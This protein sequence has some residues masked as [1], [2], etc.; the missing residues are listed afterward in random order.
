MPSHSR[1][2]R[3]AFA[4]LALPAVLCAQRATPRPPTVAGPVDTAFFG[5]QWRNIGPNSTS[6]MVAVAGSVAR[7]KEYWFGTTGGGVWKTT[8]GGT[9]VVPVT[10][11][12][13]GGTIGAIAVS[14]SNPDV[15]YVG[16]GETPIRGNV[17]HGDGVWKTT[18]AGKTWTYVGLKETQYISR[19]R[20]H[21]TNPDI[22]YVGALGHVFGPN[23]E[24]GVFK[25]TDGGRT[26][27]K[28]LF[29]ND[30]T[31]IADL[32]V[33]PGNPNVLYAAFWQAWRRPW[34]L[35]SGGPGSGIFK[36]T[37]GGEHWTE[38]TRNPGLPAT[39]VLGRIGVA[40]SPAKPSRVWAIIEHE[41]AGGV[42]RSDDGG[43]NWTFLN[44]DR[45]LRQRAWYYTNI[46]ADPKDTNVVVAPQVG[47]LWSRD[48][49]KS[50]G[51]GFGGGDNHD[52]WWA[53][54]DP[55]RLAV[56]HDNGA[57]LT[58]DGGTTAVRV[59]IPTGQYYH[60]HLTNHYPYHVCGA[61]QDAGTSCGPVRVAGGGGRG[62]GGGG[63]GRGGGAA[64]SPFSEFYG[65]AGGESGYVASNPLDPDI[66]YGGNYSGVLQRQDRRT[67]LS[68]RL[69]PWPL[70]PMG[71]DAQDAKY[72]FQWTYPIMNSPHDPHVLYV[73]ANVLFKSSDDGRTWQVISPD[74]TRHD[75]RTLGS[76]GGPI[77]KDQTSVEYYATIFAAAES[78]VTPG[79]IWA[80][81]DD[82]L[83]HVTRD[84]GKTWRNVTP[85]GFPEW[86]RVSII[87]PSPHHA[88]TAYVAANRFQMD[89][90]A[91]YLY[92]TTD[93][94]ATWTK[95]TDGITGTEFTRAIR[96]DLVRPGL[97]YAA[98]ERGVWLSYDAGG[99]WQ[100]LQRN[101]PPV[102]VH[103]IALKHDD[104]VIATHGRAFWVMENLTPLREAPEVALAAGKNYFYRPAPVI[105]AGGAPATVMYRLAQANQPVTI[106]FL[107]AA[108]KLIRKF[109]S[110]DSQPGAAGGRGGG[111]GA[112]AGGG[113]GG[114]GGAPTVTTRAGVNSYQWNLRYPD[115]SSFQGMIF[116]AGGVQ[117]P[118]AAPG[119]YTVRLTVGAE[120]PI[121]Q[122]LVIK[123]DPRAKATDADLVAQHQLAIKVRDRVTEANDAVKTMR[124]VYRQLD[125]RTPKMTA[126]SE[127]APLAKTLADSLHAV[128]DSVYQTK[129]RS[130]QDPLNFPVR[131]NNQLAA[132]LGFIGSGD[133]RPPPQAYEVFNALSPRLEGQLVRMKKSLDTML[134]KLNALLRAAGQPPIV[135]TKDEPPARP[136]V[137]M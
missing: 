3:G 109:A 53:S 66:T 47:Q 67:G 106:E 80:G 98:T 119:T 40:V 104:L 122:P 1:L 87:D 60:V 39:G 137:A 17:S 99:H 30:S 92:R 46:Y 91:P 115:A 16:G 84:G 108:G 78:P 77:T 86:T 95:I 79:L 74:L 116:W 136:N 107:D 127:F 41:P 8:D 128:E 48:G 130:G 35:W 43:A 100:S 32:I 103:D 37:D 110:T 62:G 33:E 118:L 90:F 7:P 55:K 111:E 83:I 2:A 133:R 96:E 61:K 81:S 23:A 120:K 64:P 6:R 11:K 4:V 26:W 52:I 93:Y 121:T 71:H 49:G 89:D 5:V 102:P 58:T 82:G 85:R 20:I 59:Q 113:R 24:R 75:P 126:T 134:P 9:T 129:N 50:F 131:L 42:Y 65:V 94:G 13:F 18:D 70:N 114:F 72:R 56:A 135:P 36:T 63:G 76:S 88:G 31:G 51:R 73:G 105:R 132:L 19:V 57:I 54:D 14:E 25:T 29:R 117:G 97:L 69:D 68:E 112:A 28:V 123:R 125:D 124:S 21:P 12:Y 101:L 45:N 15:V 34:Q 27:R 44:G 10:D 38:I 22:V